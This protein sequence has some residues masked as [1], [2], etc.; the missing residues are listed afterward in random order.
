MNS[1]KGDTIYTED[2]RS[3][4]RILR[5]RLVSGQS[6]PSLRTWVLGFQA[7]WGGKKNVA[8]ARKCPE[9]KLDLFSKCYGGDWV[10]V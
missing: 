1:G 3:S 5:P 8:V 7:P 10:K 9:L 6:V 2:Y 4:L